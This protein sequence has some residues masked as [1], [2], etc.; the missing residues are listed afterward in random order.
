MEIILETERLF[1][2]E[3]VSS[4][5]F[6]FFHLNNDLEVMQFTGDKAFN[7]MDEAQEFIDGYDDY[8]KNGFGRWAVCLKTTNLFVGWCG[9]KLDKK[10]NEVDIGYRF[11]KKYWG[12]GFATEAA[13]GC[14]DYGFST[15][16]LKMIVGRSYV[17]NKASIKVLEK[18]NLTFEKE[19]L[20]DNK[21]AVLYTI[22]NDSN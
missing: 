8:R 22:Y 11:Y 20:Y 5:G 16:N 9:L 10:T 12:E 18:C 1:L 14:I 2:R 15:L 21:S 19:I 3:F 17:K 6:H 7:S 4:D 13:K